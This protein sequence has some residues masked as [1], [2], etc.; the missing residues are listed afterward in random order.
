LPHDNVRWTTRQGSTISTEACG[1]FIAVH[2]DASG[3]THLLDAMSS[4]VLCFV[5]ERPRD[6]QELV[7]FVQQALENPDVTWAEVEAKLLRPLEAS[8]LVERL[9]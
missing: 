7:H 9:A 1:D 8:A 5:A 6:H 3:L 2:C 4:E